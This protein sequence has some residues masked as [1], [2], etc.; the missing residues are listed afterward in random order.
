VANRRSAAL[1]GCFHALAHPIRRAIL[2]RLVYG[3]A[4]IGVVCEDFYVA[5]PT[6]SKHLGVLED[7]GLVTRERVGRD[8]ILTLKAAPLR[9]ATTWMSRYSRFWDERLDALDELVAKL[10]DEDAKGRTKERKR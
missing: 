4:T 1:D 5:A 6:I 2:D 7:A 9:E 3:P 8:H 10:D